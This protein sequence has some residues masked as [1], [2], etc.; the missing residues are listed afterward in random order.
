[1][2]RILDGVVLILSAGI[3]PADNALPISSVDAAKLNTLAVGDTVYLT[4]RD[5]T[6]IEQTMYTHVTPLAITAGT[7]S[8]PVLR[9]QVGTTARSWPIKSCVKT[10]ITEGVLNKMICQKISGGCL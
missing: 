6:R 7:I 9:A 10:E 8:I 4:L 3:I 2:L 1:M 5:G